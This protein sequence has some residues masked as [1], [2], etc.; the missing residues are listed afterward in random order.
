MTAFI[1]LNKHL[2]IHNGT[3][4]GLNQ[5][6]NSITKQSSKFLSDKEVYSEC[7]SG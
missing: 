1:I 4:A 2:S 3:T 6:L 7:G 5:L